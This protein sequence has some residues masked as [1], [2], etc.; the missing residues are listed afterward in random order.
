MFVDDIKL[1]RGAGRLEVK[2]SAKEP[3]GIGE[4]D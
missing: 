4:I 3:Q 2:P 1:G